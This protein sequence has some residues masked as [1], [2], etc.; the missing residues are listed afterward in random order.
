MPEE[1]LLPQ[2]ADLLRQLLLHNLRERKVQ[3]LVILRLKSIDGESLSEADRER[4]AELILYDITTSRA[5]ERR[6]LRFKEVIPVN[7]E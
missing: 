6:A 2:L 1:D 7:E 3:E 5:A 4:L